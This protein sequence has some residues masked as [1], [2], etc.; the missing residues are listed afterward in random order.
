MSTPFTYQGSLVYPPDAGQ[1]A[2]TRAFSISGNYD[3][4]A[5]FDFELV[6]A[7]TQVVDFGSVADA[8][9]ILVEVASDAAAPV[10]LRFNGGTDD[11]E[12]SA[13]GFYASANPTPSTGISAL[14]LVHTGDAKVT[15]YILG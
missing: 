12:I 5:E 6:G 9:A 1:P 3:V 14:S 11:H 8:K 4:K 13:S 7:G 2:A 15:V 10:N